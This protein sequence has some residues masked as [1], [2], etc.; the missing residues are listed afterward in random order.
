MVFETLWVS[1]AVWAC[2][3]ISG[4]GFD[5]KL[6]N[7][8]LQPQ[9]QVIPGADQYEAHQNCSTAG[10]V[11]K[12]QLEPTLHNLPGAKTSYGLEIHTS[13]PNNVRDLN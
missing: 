2:T 4:G 13:C 9:S 6:A 3:S 8:S 11:L 10:E 5:C 12:N 7:Y 1:A